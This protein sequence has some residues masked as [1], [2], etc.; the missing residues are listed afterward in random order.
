MIEG[1]EVGS[2][3]KAYSLATYRGIRLVRTGSHSSLV[4]ELVIKML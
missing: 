3:S 1:N 2:L 4:V